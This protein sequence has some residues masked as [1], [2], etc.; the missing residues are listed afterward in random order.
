[1]RRI[2]LL[3]LLLALLGIILSSCNGKDVK[4]VRCQADLEG[5]SLRAAR[6]KEYAHLCEPHP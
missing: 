5:A 6:E 3:P 4:V 2:H 1:M